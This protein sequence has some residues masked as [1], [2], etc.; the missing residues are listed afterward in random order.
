IMS[1][2]PA[3]RPPMQTASP[4]ASRGGRLRALWRAGCRK[5]GSMLERPARAPRMP[6]APARAVNPPPAPA[7]AFEI[8]QAF[9]EALILT[10]MP[11]L[12]ARIVATLRARF[13]HLHLP[14]IGERAP[15]AFEAAA[16]HRRPRALWPRTLATTRLC[17][18][19]TAL[20]DQRIRMAR[21]YLLRDCRH[22]CR[23]ASHRARDIAPAMTA[24]A[25]PPASGRRSESRMAPRPL[26]RRPDDDAARQP[27]TDRPEPEPRR[28]PFDRLAR[29]PPRP[30][31]GRLRRHPIAEPFQ[32]PRK[33]RDRG[34]YR[35][36][37]RGARYMA[38]FN[39]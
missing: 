18:T 1:R 3:I 34:R 27:A 15:A 39:T 19:M 33:A 14:G 9:I 16:L 30:P 29:P 37:N 17:T 11:G 2:A 7:T 10:C 24:G 23:A 22:C 12:S 36:G 26:R 8:D 38:L 20:L 6:R 21:L 35:V 5:V 32:P 4:A 13:D 31:P 25:S 28:R